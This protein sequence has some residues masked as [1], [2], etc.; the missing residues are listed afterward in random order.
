MGRLKVTVVT[1]EGIFGK[2]FLFKKKQ[3]TEK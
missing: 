1:F 3:A 2:N